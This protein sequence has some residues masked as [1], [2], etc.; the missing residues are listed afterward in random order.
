MSGD[1]FIILVTDIVFNQTEVVPKAKKIG[2]YCS[3]DLR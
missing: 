1:Q 3:A 2:N